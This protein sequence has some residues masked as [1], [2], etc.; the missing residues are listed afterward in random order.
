MLGRNHLS[1][2]RKQK[3]RPLSVIWAQLRLKSVLR[4]LRHRFEKRRSSD[5]LYQRKHLGRRKKA[6]F[7]DI[8]VAIWCGKYHMNPSREGDPKKGQNPARIAFGDLKVRFY[9]LPG[10]GLYG[11]YRTE[12]WAQQN[13]PKIPKSTKKRSKKCVL[14][15]PDR[16]IGADFTAAFRPARASK[17]A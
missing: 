16:D 12:R 10:T 5:F 14:S 9:C 1:T 4:A 8:L 7:L 15:L 13:D 2:I 6:H 3:I 11:I 17:R